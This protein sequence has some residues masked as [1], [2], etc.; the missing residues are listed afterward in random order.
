[1]NARFQSLFHERGTGRAVLPRRQAERQLGP[2]KYKI[3]AELCDG[4]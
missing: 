2:A 3:L 1:M 4:K